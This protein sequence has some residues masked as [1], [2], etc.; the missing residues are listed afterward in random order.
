[1]YA[2][3]YS[4]SIILYFIRYVQYFWNAW[5]DMASDLPV[6]SSAPSVAPSPR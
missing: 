4:M 6:S 1:M 3:L 5:G 2:I